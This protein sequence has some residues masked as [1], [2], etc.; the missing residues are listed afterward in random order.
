MPNQAC[1]INHLVFLK[2]VTKAVD[3]GK[4]VDVIYLDFAKAFELVPRQQLL[5]TEGGPQWQGLWMGQ[6]HI[7]CPLG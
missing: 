2:A 6:F 7:W 1:A 3:E 5:E 4:N